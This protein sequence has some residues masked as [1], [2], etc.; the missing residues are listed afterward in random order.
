MVKPTPPPAPP[1]RV[2]LKGECSVYSTDGLTCFL[3][4]QYVP[5][6]IHHECTVDGGVR[7]VRNRPC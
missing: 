5:P 2:T 4:G 6:N 7:T 3:C 1:L